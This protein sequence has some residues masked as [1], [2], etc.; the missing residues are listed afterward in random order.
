VYDLSFVVV[1]LSK[2]LHCARKM[3]QKMFDVGKNATF[4][5]L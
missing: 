1:K 3:E 5:L 4:A 2:S